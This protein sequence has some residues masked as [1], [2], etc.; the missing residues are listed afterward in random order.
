MTTMM[1]GLC[2]EDLAVLSKAIPA[3]MLASHRT[4]EQDTPLSFAVRHNCVASVHTLVKG[5]GFQ[6]MVFKEVGIVP[7]LKP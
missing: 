1:L 6:D 4:A 7:H 3:S 2:A 5:S